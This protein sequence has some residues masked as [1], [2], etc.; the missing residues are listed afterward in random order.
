MAARCMKLP[1]L[2][3]SI[4]VCAIISMLATQWSYQYAEAKHCDKLD[5]SISRDE[6]GHD[7][8]PCERDG[9]RLA[10]G[11]VSSGPGFG[12]GAGGN[13][14]VNNSK[15]SGGI[16]GNVGSGNGGVGGNNSG[17][18]K[19]GGSGSSRGSNAGNSGGSGGGLGNAGSGN[20]GL[21]N[22]GSAAGNNFGNGTALGGG[23][24]VGL[25][26]GSLRV[27]YYDLSCPSAE[28]I[29]RAAFTGNI[30]SDP[31]APAA[32]L[33]LVFHDCQVGGCDASI[34]LD[35]GGSDTSEL[36]SE[37]NFGIRRLDF[38]DQIKATVE[39]ACPGVVSC[40]DIIVLAA[41]EAIAISGGPRIIVQTGRRDSLFASNLVA[42]VSLPRASVN[43]DTFL[44]IFQTKGMTVPESVAILGAHTI[45][46]GHCVNVVDR[47]YPSTDVTLGTFFSG[48]LKFQCPTNL[49]QGMNN[50]TVINNDLTNLIFDNQYFRDVMSGRGLFFIDAQLGLDP[51]TSPSVAAFA[52]NQQLFF[53]IFGIAFKKLTASNV[54]TGNY[55]QIRQNCHYTV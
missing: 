25:G 22:G 55:G 41:R 53:D 44:D 21:G 29:V 35:S 7:R 45:G 46:I 39:F 50:N 27:G 16:L 52:A 10:G 51:R 32:L 54:L 8:L 3:R 48:Q 23:A 33:R 31:T 40:S 1:A 5:G 28:A 11:G 2:P 36:L 26:V 43:I 42:D 14:G 38:I 34:L 6:D 30:L 4:F 37:K 18:A 20:G 15:G 17:A 47:L 9:R 13:S 24:G 49:P 12:N 19:G